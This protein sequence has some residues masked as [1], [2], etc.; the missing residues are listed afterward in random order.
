M[1]VYL[2]HEEKDHKGSYCF[3]EAK[4]VLAIVLWIYQRGEGLISLLSLVDL[5]KKDIYF[6]F[7][8]CSD[9]FWLH[10]KEAKQH[11]GHINKVYERS[12]FEFGHMKPTHCS[13]VFWPWGDQLGLFF[14][15]SRQ[16][17]NINIFIVGVDF[18]YSS[19]FKRPVYKIIE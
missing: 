10:G 4:E 18:L 14:W 15:P 12:N 19:S 8:F 11:K 6:Q 16:C 2:R 1:G 9:T 5:S 7:L 17:K 13:Q 3:L